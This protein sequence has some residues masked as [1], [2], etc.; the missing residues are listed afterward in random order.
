MVLLQHLRPGA[1]DLQPACCLLDAHAA[2]FSGSGRAAPST[3]PVCG[4]SVSTN[5]CL[6]VALSLTIYLTLSRATQLT[7]QP[8][9]SLPPAC[10]Q[11]GSSLYV[12]TPLHLRKCATLQRCES[13]PSYLHE[14]L[15][16]SPPGA[17][18]LRGRPAGPPRDL[19]RRVVP[20][21]PAGVVA[22][23]P[24]CGNPT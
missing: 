17:P 18:R 7:T 21:A 13:C 1:G 10:L 16:P 9:S 20:T 8:A 5:L 6:R 24:R 19:Q 11:P 3:P 23:T 4:Y 22:V 2:A 15:E 14:L 12:V